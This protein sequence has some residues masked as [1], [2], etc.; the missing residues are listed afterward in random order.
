[1][2]KENKLPERINENFPI[3]SQNGFEVLDLVRQ[4]NNLS[5]G[6]SGRIPIYKK[7]KEKVDYEVDCE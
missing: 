1:M 6:D 5:V 7:I 2:P 3:M 4:Y